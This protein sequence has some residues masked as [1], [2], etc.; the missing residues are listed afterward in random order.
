MFRQITV[1]CCLLFSAISAYSATDYEITKKMMSM[2]DTANL[3]NYIYHLAGE[4]PVSYGDTLIS[5]TDRS[6]YSGTNVVAA[7]YI[8]SVLKEFGYQPNDYFARAVY[9]GH[10]VRNVIASP[11]AIDT[12]KLTLV[13][14]GHYDSIKHHVGADDNASGVVGIM[15]IARIFRSFDTDVNVVFGFW[16]ARQDGQLGSIHIAD[17]LYD[18]GC[19]KLIYVNLDAISTPAM[20]NNLDYYADSLTQSKIVNYCQEHKDVIN[21]TANV[22][23]KKLYG[24][25]F[26]VFSWYFWSFYSYSDYQYTEQMSYQFD[27]PRFIDFDFFGKMVKHGIMAICAL[28]DI[29]E[30]PSDVGEIKSELDYNIYPNPA[31]EYFRVIVGGASHVTVRNALGNCVYTA[32]VES[33]A[34]VK[35]NNLPQG[36]Y[37]VGINQREKSVTVPVVVVK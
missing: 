9:Y 34:N 5:L 35:T 19:K 30:K 26:D 33:E 32:D 17:S 18:L 12:N 23:T 13:I 4:T 10:E 2:V 6:L 11:R 24:S 20:E 31:K 3:R 15:E 21:F 1:L 27:V 37:Y 29:T 28:I 22:A 7:W 14:G 25:D 8:A 16:D 36:V